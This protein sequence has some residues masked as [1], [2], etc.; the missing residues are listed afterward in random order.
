VKF[1]HMIDAKTFPLGRLVD[2]SAGFPFRSAIKAVRNS[3]VRVIQMKDVDPEAGIA[4]HTAVCTRL[5]GR[6]QAD[7]LRPGDVL[8]IPKGTRFYAVCADA[9]PGPAVCGPHFFLL[10][11]KP[12]APVS[13]AFLA[14]QINQ[15]PFQR[16]LRKAA[17]GS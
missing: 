12:G 8:F 16:Q 5:N 4:W 13:P 7:W 14:W 10:R 17:E 11:A 6:R 3:E 1:A 9:P 2:V 15:P